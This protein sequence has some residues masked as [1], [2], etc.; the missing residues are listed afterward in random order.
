MNERRLDTIVEREQTSPRSS[1]CRA[2]TR[3]DVKGDNDDV[4]DAMSVHDVVV[5]VG[6]VGRWR[7][8]RRNS[9]TWKKVRRYANAKCLGCATLRDA[10]RARNYGGRAVIISSR[11]SVNDRR[12]VI[13]ERNARSES[14]K[15]TRPIDSRASREARG[16]FCISPHRAIDRVRTFSLSLCLSYF[17]SSPRD[18][19]RRMHQTT[20]N[21]MIAR[22]RGKIARVRSGAR[23]GGAIRGRNREADPTRFST[24]R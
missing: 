11:A 6:T 5:A 16:S 23:E 13:I 4:V 2:S 10:R 19:S 12:V 3:R 1:N 20:L 18:V 14:G 8:R 9:T 7:R 21:S 15:L 22:A 17:R 24:P